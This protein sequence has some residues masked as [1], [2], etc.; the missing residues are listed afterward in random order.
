MP[1]DL[2]Q[3]L[4]QDQPTESVSMPLNEI[5]RKAE[6]L[7]TKG[8]LKAL[9]SI[10]LGLLMCVVFARA[11]ARQHNTIARL[12]YGVL[13]FSCI[14]F[15]VQS[16]KWVWPGRLASDAAQ[17]TCLSFYRRELEKRRDYT[18]HIWSRSGLLVMFT[19][20]AVLVIP[21]L[22]TAPRY[23]PKAAPL[24]ILLAVWFAIFLPKRK[25]EQQKLQRELDEL[26]ALE[27][28]AQ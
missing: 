20:L 4:W 23:L 11:F 24:F 6:E 14:L 9:V 25:R 22:V 8:R 5:R 1:N 19:G 12:G 28:D 18:L 17:Q 3:Q 15:A 7:Q 16:Y 26:N 2:L 27:R 10:V 13:V 21:P